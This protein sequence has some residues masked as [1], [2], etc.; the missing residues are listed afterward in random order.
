MPAQGSSPLKVT[1]HWPEAVY[2]E[3][4]P[5]SEDRFLAISDGGKATIVFERDENGLVREVFVETDGV[6]FSAEKLR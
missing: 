6:K 3:L 1:W 4:L 5:Q 2:D